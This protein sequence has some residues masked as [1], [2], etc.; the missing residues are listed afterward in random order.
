MGAFL[1]SAGFLINENEN[2]EFEGKVAQHVFKT[3]LF[4]RIR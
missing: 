4:Y 3:F 1:I 2:G